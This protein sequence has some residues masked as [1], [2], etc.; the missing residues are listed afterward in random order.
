M[1]GISAY[2]LGEKVWLVR[3]DKTAQVEFPQTIPIGS[4]VLT[5][6]D[7]KA[8]TQQLGMARAA[9]RNRQKRREGAA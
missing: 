6:Q 8:F 2:A 5:E 4:V 7:A 9:V 3:T 1:S